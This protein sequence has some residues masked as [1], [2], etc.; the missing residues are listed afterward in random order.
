M[1]T[2]KQIV[3]PQHKNILQTVG[4]NI[5]LARKRR[6]LTTVQLAER[7]DISR[8]TLYL[9]ETGN[10]RVAIGSYFNVLRVLGMQSDFL[11]LAAD[12][13]LGRKIQDMKLL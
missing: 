3:F 10:E 9:I 12:D 2:K 5:K 8:N 1:K 13:T 6:E 11:Q 7:A 4:E